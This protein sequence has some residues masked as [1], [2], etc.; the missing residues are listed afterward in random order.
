[1]TFLALAEVL[2]R[3]ALGVL[4]DVMVRT[5]TITH[6]QLVQAAPEPDTSQPATGRQGQWLA[7]PDLRFGAERVV[8]EY[9]GRQHRDRAEQYE[10]DLPR[11]ELMDR[12]GGMSSWRAVLRP[13]YPLRRNRGTL[14]GC[15]CC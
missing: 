7:T 1:M 5:E 4:G 10:R 12:R 2:A 6:E 13:P 11:R 14:S 15:P 9:D 8:V 3:I